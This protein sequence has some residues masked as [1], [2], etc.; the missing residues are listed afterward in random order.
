[1][2]PSARWLFL[3][4]RVTMAVQVATSAHFKLV[5]PASWLIENERGD[6]QK[7]GPCGGSNTDWGKPSYV[8]SKAM[9][10]QKL[11]VKVQETIYHPGHY[12]VALA[13]NSPTSCRSIRRS[14][15]T[16]ATVGR[17]PCRR[18]SRTRPD[19]GARRRSVRA[20]R[21]PDR[22]RWRPSRPTCSCRTSA[23]RSARCKSCNS[24]PSTG[25]TILAATPIITAPN[26]R[27]RKDPSQAASRRGLAGG[28]LSG[29]NPRHRW[30]A[31]SCRPATLTSTHAFRL[32]SGRGLNGA[33]RHRA[34]R[35]SSVERLPDQDDCAVRH[36]AAARRLRHAVHRLSGARH[37]QG[38]GPGDESV[39]AGLQRGAH[40]PDDW[41]ARQ[42]SDC[43]SVRPQGCRNGLRADLCLSSHILTARGRDAAGVRAVSAS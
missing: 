23:A 40:R 39:R 11:H 20:C 19:S 5:E 6:P 35:R 16:T 28:A 38:A 43:R 1:M 37:R 34:H 18:R 14:R 36:G 3:G 32:E 2:K 33:H 8:I 10:G 26:C 42:R 13:V 21:A 30:L 29:S 12:R 4:R 9:G 27:S 41:R 25:S 24:W 15:R 22:P 17:S 31:A 7:A